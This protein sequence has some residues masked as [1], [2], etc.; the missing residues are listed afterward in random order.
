MTH[1]AFY[2]IKEYFVQRIDK[3]RS[4]HVLQTHL[5]AIKCKNFTRVM[6]GLTKQSHP[7]HPCRGRHSEIVRAQEKKRRNTVLRVHDIIYWV[8]VKKN[9][10]SSSPW[11]NS[12]IFVTISTAAVV[13]D[14][15]EFFLP[16][17]TGPSPC[18]ARRGTRCRWF[19]RRR[20]RAVARR[21]M[22]D[23][24]RRPRRST[25]SHPVSKSL[26]SGPA[27]NSATST[28]AENRHRHPACCCD[29]CFLQKIKNH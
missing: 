21:R 7:L 4:S 5:Y 14:Y 10:S 23:D 1:T 25:G 15:I 19:R 13:R 18:C 2:C 11:L 29:W 28:P 16:L 6:T 27:L 12:E 22:R 17:F 3:K 20:R 24:A 8:Q 9:I 26:V